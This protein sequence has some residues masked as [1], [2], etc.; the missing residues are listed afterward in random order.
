MA[1]AGGGLGVARGVETARA[2][3]P[4]AADAVRLA[5]EAG[6]ELAAA[7]AGGAGAGIVLH[8]AWRVLR[9]RA[10]PSNRCAGRARPRGSD[11]PDGRSGASGASSAGPPGP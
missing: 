10:G 4:G 11:R 2:V 8:G 1:L 5:A 3:A 7:A 9:T 6:D